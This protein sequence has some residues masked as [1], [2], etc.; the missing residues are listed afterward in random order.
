MAKKAGDW[1]MVVGMIIM[2][3]GLGQKIELVEKK[4]IIVEKNQVL[5]DSSEL[6]NINK[7]SKR[8]LMSLPR[9]GEKIAQRIIEY[10]QLHNGF[11]SK[12]EIKEVSGIGDKTY[13][14]LKNK[15]SF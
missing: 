7:A 5:G 6:I 10:R 1:L 15:I 8:E 14:E 4:E 13:E 9:V 11:K 3:V 12:V 2:V